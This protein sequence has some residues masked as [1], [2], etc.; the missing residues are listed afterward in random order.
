MRDSTVR[1][2]AL[3]YR[4][5]QTVRARDRALEQLLEYIKACIGDAYEDGRAR[6]AALGRDG[7]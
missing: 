1:A 3:A 4:D 2:L 5:A 7:F 6:Q